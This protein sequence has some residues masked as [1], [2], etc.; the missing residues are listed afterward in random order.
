[1][2]WSE[3]FSE[4]LNQWVYVVRIGVAVICGAAIGLERS[5]RQKE[6]GIRT[7]IIVSIG[8]ALMMIVSKYGFFDVVGLDGVSLDASRI[9]ANIITGISFLGAGVIFLKGGAVKGL[10]T[11][12][13]LWT[14]A[15]VAM[16][17]GAGM[18]LLGIFI[19]A[20]V[21]IIQHVLHRYNLSSETISSNE[22]T[23]LFRDS[24]ET[25]N[26]IKNQ[27]VDRNILVQEFSLKKLEN[28]IVK[29]TLTVKISE[30]L[31]LEELMIMADKMEEIL[32]ISVTT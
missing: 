21:I 26:M 2:N 20:L 6:A 31:A 11:A 9:A 7:H 24:E 32:E 14:T 30:N 25:L 5:R 15:G 28:G 17:V 12:A 3:F 16:T 19:T 13:G 8:A 22:I 10:T 1:M 27:F 18:Y 23:I 4:T 29:M